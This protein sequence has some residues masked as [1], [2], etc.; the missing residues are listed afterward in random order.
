MLTRARA[1]LLALALSP[2]VSCQG[3]GAAPAGASAGAAAPA[4]APGAD[5]FDLREPGVRAGGVRLIPVQT[6]KGTFNV[7]TKRFGNGR[8][9][10]LLLHG[11]PAATH[12][13]FECAESFFPR[14]GIEFYEYDQLGSHYS[15]QP[16]DDA[17]WTVPRFVDE[18]EQ[19]RKALGL[20]QFYLLGHSWGGILAIEYALAHQAHLKGLIVSNMMASAPDYQA[21]N[22]NVLQ[23]QMAP[24]E[25]EA[26]KALERAGK[27]SGPEYEQRLQ[28]FYDAHVVRLKPAPDPV[29][30]AFKHI[31]TKIYALMQGPSEFGI[32]GRLEKWDRKADLPK[33]AVPTLTVGAAH[34]TMDPAHMKWMATQVQQGASL[35]CPQ[36]SHLSM[37]DDQATYFRGVI[38]FLKAVDGGTFKKGMTF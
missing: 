37:W 25:V 36:G 12:E 26:I 14:E 30:R 2:L 1:A 34:D 3:G 35:H 7:W 8:I 31:N 6:P 33:I 15:D 17:L 24:G 38:G 20:E 21:Y 9:K 4:A 22:E 16:D 11:G 32:S 29:A 23:K 19:V 10:V 28:G 13:Y 5:Y 18:V 27:T